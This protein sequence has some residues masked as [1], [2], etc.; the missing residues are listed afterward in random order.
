MLNVNHANKVLFHYS[1]FYSLAHSNE[2]V[3]TLIQKAISSE[4]ACA[5]WNLFDQRSLWR[6]EMLQH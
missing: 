5:T 1:P 3:I 6:P 2:F 4:M